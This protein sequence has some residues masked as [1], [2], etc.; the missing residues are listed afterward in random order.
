[1]INATVAR[2]ASKMENKKRPEKELKRVEDAIKQAIEKGE[3]HIHI[4]YLLCTENV[5][6]LQDLG[7]MVQSIYDDDAAF[8]RTYTNIRW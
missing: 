5:K 2:N 8:R 6:I 3:Y 1:M 7:Y 4:D